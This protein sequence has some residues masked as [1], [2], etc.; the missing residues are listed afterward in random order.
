MPALLHEVVLS[1]LLPLSILC[2]IHGPP[3][4]A[5]LRAC[6]ARRK[7]AHDVC[8][9]LCSA[10]TL[11]LPNFLKIFPCLNLPH[12]R[13]SSDTQQ[14]AQA[15]TPCQSLDAQQHTQA[16]MPSAQ[17]IARVALVVYRWRSCTQAS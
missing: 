12:H 9:P 16:R 8:L 14:R 17:D 3:T 10:A 13:W 6:A 11:G 7:H 15:H 4:E 1:D 5:Q 2:Q